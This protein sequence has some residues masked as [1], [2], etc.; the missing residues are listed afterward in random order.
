M[1]MGAWGTDT[2]DN[3]SAADW[4]AEF[5]EDGA[6]V[7]L[8]AAFDAVFDEEYVEVDTGSAALAACEVVARLRGK[9]GRRNPST[10]P[11]DTWVAG[12]PQPPP[13]ELVALALRAID[14]IT[15]HDSELAELWEGDPEWKTAVADLRKRVAG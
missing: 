2:F 7:Q 15:A 3:D 6:L 4:A 14:R 1:T 5:A 12:H 9:W 13:K 11:V 8:Q 10:E